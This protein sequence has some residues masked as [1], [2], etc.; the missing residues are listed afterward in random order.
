MRLSI[1][2]EVALLTETGAVLDAAASTPGAVNTE[3]LEPKKPLQLLGGQ[4][5]AS[6]QTRLHLPHDGSAPAL[7]IGAVSDFQRTPWRGKVTEVDTRLVV[8]ATNA[9]GEVIRSADVTIS[10][11]P[12]PS[13]E[14]RVFAVTTT[15]QNPANPAQPNVLTGRDAVPSAIS[16]LRSA[17]RRL[18]T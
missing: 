10:D 16:T 12:R 9:Q 14:D 11:Y 17:R 5:V 15:T 6:T 3:T 7:D 2:Q 13:R 8:E 4:N 1:R 18:R